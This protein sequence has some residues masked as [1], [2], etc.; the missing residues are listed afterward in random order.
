MRQ[1]A[2][3]I[4][5]IT[6]SSNTVLEPVTSALTRDLADVSVHFTRLRVTRISLDPQD[7]DQ[8]AQEAFVRAAQLLA[9]A[10]V[11]VIAWHGTSGSWLGPDH[12]RQM[13]RAIEDA[14]GIRATTATLALLAALEHCRTQRLGLLTPY[15][16]DLAGAITGHYAARGFPVHAAHHFA[17]TTNYD[18]ALTTDGELDTAFD[19]L[20]ARGCDTVAVVCTNL[21]AA[22]LAK[23]WEQRRPVTVVDSVAATLWQ[24]LRLAGDATPIQGYGRLLAD[25]PPIA[26]APAGPRHPHATPD[27]HHTQ[28]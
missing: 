12:D 3:R 6:P 1:A 10:R 28:T 5:M 8:F 7:T 13:C 27:A 21:R 15:T 16:D 9:D 17:R 26:A 2:L 20:A 18:F 25:L 4:G 24:A 22:H 14:T 23:R 19:T 11:D